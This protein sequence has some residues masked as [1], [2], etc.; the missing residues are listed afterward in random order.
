MES[1]DDVFC[2]IGPWRQANASCAAHW[3]IIAAAIL[4]RVV[5]SPSRILGVH[6]LATS[7]RSAVRFMPIKAGAGHEQQGFN[8]VPETV[9]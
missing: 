8:L 1:S 9:L 5:Q 2:R 3:R 7:I 6:S 4:N